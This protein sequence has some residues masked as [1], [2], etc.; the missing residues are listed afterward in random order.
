MIKK[1]VLMC[2]ILAS[3]ANADPIRDLPKAELHLHLTGSYPLS[4]LQS[5]AKESAEIEELRAFENSL[6][7]LA[8]GVPYEMAFSYF[9]P[10]EKL[11]NTYDKV[12][13]GVTALCHELLVDG[14]VY[15]EIRTGLK[16]LGK[17]Y[18]EYLNAVL[19][20]I[21]ACP[22]NLKVNLLL[23]LRRN[24][25]AALIKETIDLAIQHQ[26]SG[27]VGIDISGDSTLGQ[28]GELVSELHRAKKEGL[29]LALHLGESAKEI[30][31]PAKESE[32]AAILETLKPERIGHGVFLSKQAQKWIFDH[33]SVPI[34]VCPTSSVLAG[35]ID[36]H[37]NH[38]GVSYYLDQKHP[39]VVGTDDPLLFQT[40]LTQEYRKLMQHEAIT[41]TEVKRMIAWSFEFSF[42]SKKEKEE[43]RSLEILDLK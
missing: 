28:I 19:K 26:K 37:S 12:E 10:V 39:I 16:N 22:K 15:A 6:T 43:Y 8:K 35:M 21:H 38:P 36:H 5:I 30:D 14:V 9:L 24:T 20:G 32:Q 3:V 13:K 11:V 27:V 2:S 29:F 31:T 41:L 34:E 17:G 42:M 18:E 25:P 40:T 4:Y 23:S 1:V 33:P 7:T